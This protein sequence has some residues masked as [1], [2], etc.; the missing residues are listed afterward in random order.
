MDFQAILNGS[1]S[2]LITGGSLF[3]LVGIFFGWFLIPG[4]LHWFRLRGIQR[5]I[6]KFESK[7]FADEFKNVFLRD[8]QLSHLWKQYQDSLHTQH[9]NSDGQRVVVATRATVP[10]EIYFNNQF[11]VDS[12]LATEFFKHLPGIFTGLGIIGT[13]F[14]LIEGLNA[15]QVSEN[16]AAVRTSLESLMHTVGHAFLISAIAISA[17]M[18]VT[19]IEKILL[20]SLYRRTEDIAHAIDARFDTGAGEE[21]LSRLVTASEDSASQSKILKDALVT[22]LGVLLRELTNAQIASS[23]KAAVFQAKAARHDNQ[24]LGAAISDSIQKSLQ[25]PL[26]SIA[27][28]VK[29]AS[30]DQSAAAA[31]MLQDVMV[32]FTQRL[33]DLFGGQISGLSDL[34]QQTA[35]SMQEAVGTLQALVT[36][37]EDSSRRSTD[38]MA[39]RMAQTIEKM[40]A[41][42]GAMNSQSA[43]F[44]EQMRQL[45]ASSQ[46]ETNQKLQVSLE[47][48]GT[49]VAGMLATLSESQTKVFEE[50]RSREQ[51]MTDRNQRA[52]NSMSETVEAAIKEM[53]AASVQMS[54]NVAILSQTTSSSVDKMNAGAE[55]L[56]AASKNFATAGVRVSGVITQV[57]VVAEKLSESSEAFAS[58]GMAIQELLRDYKLQRD[59]ISMMFAEL[60]ST[61]E[62]ARREASLTGDVLARIEGAATR[63]G[64]AQKQADEYLA[65][66]SRVLGE[67]HTTFAIEVKKTL[68]RANI[69]FHTKLSSAVGLLSSSIGEL[70]ITLATMG[71]PMPTKAKS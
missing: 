60:R 58:G 30:G 67:T 12:R 49:Q 59:A 63:L 50:N 56:G 54:Q 61:V 31:R 11:V 41:R 47:A 13:F 28:T 37:I 43:A 34:N 2:F 26:E 23:E 45:V 17:A 62:F 24:I 9:Q 71:V 21:Y 42:Q 33:N 64:V 69:E 14:G 53:S 1:T 57:A 55:L 40:E 6:K 65:G 8:S 68:D 35:R 3:A 7:K 48:I 27:N 66:I 20:A 51:S 5:D 52:V 18:I 4:V 15:F 22:D 19:V 36:N 70:E 39:E 16:A 10:A 44:I 29:S 32:S 46:S 25:S 38:A